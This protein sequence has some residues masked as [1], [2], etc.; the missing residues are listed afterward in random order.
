M[1]DEIFD[2]EEEKIRV[3]NGDIRGFDIDREAIAQSIENIKSANFDK[4]IHVE[5]SD[6]AA[7][8][9]VEAMIKSYNFV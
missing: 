2:A 4:L 9:P 6:I 8:K 3:F 1:W 5:K 7:F